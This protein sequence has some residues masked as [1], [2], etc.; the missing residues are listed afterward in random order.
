MRAQL[1]ELGTERE[2]AWCLLSVSIDT[3]VKGIEGGEMDVFDHIKL[4]GV[5]KILMEIHQN[6][7]GREGVKH[8]FDTLSAE[9]FHYDV[10]HS[11]QQIVLFSHIKR[12]QI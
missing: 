1:R 11:K 12:D 6:V 2:A 3:V 7:I 8:V 5:K 4:T 10:W 9:G